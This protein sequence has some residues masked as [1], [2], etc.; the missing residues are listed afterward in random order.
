MQPVKRLPAVAAAL[1]LAVAAAACGSN[2]GEEGGVAGESQAASQAPAVSADASALEGELNVWAMGNEGA[3]LGTLAD[4]FTEEYPN[5]TV[6][7]TPVDWGQAVAKLQTAI[8]GGETPDVSQMGTD[9]MGQFAETGALEVVP[10]NF[11]AGQYFESAW[12][13]GVVDGSAYG[14]PWYVET[15][16]LYYRTDLAEQAGITEPPGSWEELKQAAT[17]MQRDAGAEWGISLGTKNWQEFLPFA[18]S[19]GAEIMTEAGEFQLASPEVVEALT[20]YDSYFEEGLSP[21]AVPEGFDITPAFVTGTHPMFLSGPWHLGLIEEAGGA[22]IEGKWDIAP[23]PGKD[24][25]PGTSF[26]GGSNLV[27]FKDSPNKEAAWAFVE[28][29]SR[30]EIQ[31]QWYEEATVLPAVQSA[32]EDPALADD[33]HLAVFGEQLQSSKAQPAIPTWAEIANAIN[34]QLERVTAGDVP[35]EEGAQAM[36]QA[37]ESIGTGR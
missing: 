35:P 20:Y 14:V 30:P 34:E 16:V 26:V 17:A 23:L 13:T 36:Q 10:E 37:A 21:T 9:M 19:N 3:L 6:N 27:V 32:W 25:P 1:C 12:N 11:D 8:G 2:D 18:W 24:G 7:V 31:I 22:D 29:L 15:R 28:Y 33:E 4:Q 5:I